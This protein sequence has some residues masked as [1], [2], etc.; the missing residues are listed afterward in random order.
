MLAEF[1]KL[2][3]AARFVVQPNAGRYP[4]LDDAESFV[5]TVTAFLDA[6]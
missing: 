1:A 5:E 6:A 4:W 3:T 2:F